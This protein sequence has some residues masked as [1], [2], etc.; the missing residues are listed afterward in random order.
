MLHLRLR[1]LIRTLPV[2][3]NMPV[4]SSLVSGTTGNGFVDACHVPG[5]TIDSVIPEVC[6]AM[7]SPES[8][9]ADQVQML[10]EIA[11]TVLITMGADILHFEGEIDRHTGILDVDWKFVPTADVCARPSPGDKMSTGLSMPTVG[12]SSTHMDNTSRMLK[13]HA[14]MRVYTRN[15][16]PHS[17]TVFSHLLGCEA[18]DLA[19]LMQHSIHVNSKSVDPEKDHQYDFSLRTNFCNTFVVCTVL[20]TL[21]DTTKLQQQQLQILQT[22]LASYEQEEYLAA[23]EGRTANHSSHAFMPSVLR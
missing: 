19:A 12:V 21:N 14:V 18:I 11:T 17:G 4:S 16:D 3:N 8:F 1:L 6:K 15:V 5:L 23:K 9:P 10:K 13:S 2:C 7:R 20:P 22:S